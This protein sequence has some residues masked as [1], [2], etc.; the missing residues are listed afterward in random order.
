[1]GC[2]Y[3]NNGII[4]S[5]INLSGTILFL[6]INSQ[7]INNSE[8]Y[9]GKKYKVELKSG[10]NLVLE[11]DWNFS[12][13][14][15]LK[16]IYLEK[17]PSS[18]TRGYLI[19][20]GLNIRKKVFIDKLNSSS[21]SVCIKD[22]ELNSISGISLSCTGTNEYEVDCPG[23][24]DNFT[25]NLPAGFFEVD[26]LTN[27]GVIEMPS[28]I[29]NTSCTPNWN[30]TVWSACSG[31]R[32]NKTCRDLN[33]CNISMPFLN[34][35]Q[36]CS[37]IG[38]CTPNWNCTNWSLCINGSQTKTCTDLN[39]CNTAAGKPDTIQSCT[40]GE[41]G[42]NLIVILIII[43]I[44]ILIIIIVI[45]IIY[46]LNKGENA[47]NS[48]STPPTTSSPSYSPPQYTS[49]HPTYSQNRQF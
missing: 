16:N 14:L 7:P 19:V 18:A 47:N 11:F 41:T 35:N 28:R 12:Q 4:N 24:N 2:D 15:N 27:S 6:F 45:L 43:G 32:Q 49:S 9:T 33:L 48:Y 1:L 37:P 46:F 20:K 8:K 39:S 44:V 26:G 42:Y 22:Q 17:Q 29:I 36:S 31:R 10:S 13:P 34:Q 40:Q 38:N 21:S 30:C 23:S 3:D 5:D 25:C